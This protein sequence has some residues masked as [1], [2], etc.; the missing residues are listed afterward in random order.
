MRTRLCHQENS[1]A[2]SLETRAHPQLGFSTPVFPAVVEEC[3]SSVDGFLDHADSGVFVSSI[4]QMMAAE[5]KCGYSDVVPSK[6][7][8]GNS[9]RGSL[10]HGLPPHYIDAV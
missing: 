10:R 1:M 9:S 7:A 3:D 2:A 6:L 8:E 5:S 4:T